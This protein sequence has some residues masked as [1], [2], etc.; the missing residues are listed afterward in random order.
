MKLPMADY[1]DLMAMRAMSGNP[2]DWVRRL[3][4]KSLA[5]RRMERELVDGMRDGDA[6][7]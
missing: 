4:V 3:I 1:N 5:R 7:P 2:S 6:L